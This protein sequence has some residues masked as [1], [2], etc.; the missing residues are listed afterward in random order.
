ML[1]TQPVNH[2]P[3]CDTL[4]ECIDDNDCVKK[5]MVGTCD[6]KT[7]KARCV[8]QES[9]RFLF[10]VLLPD[11]SHTHPENE[12]ISTTRHFFAGAAIDT[13]FAGSL[14]GK[15]MLAYYKPAALPL[16]L[17]D[18]TVTTAYNYDKIASGLVRINSRLTFKDGIVKKTWF[19]NRPSASRT[20]TVY[21][22]PLFSGARDAIAIALA[23]LKTGQANIRIMPLL[24][25]SP[26]SDSLTQEDHLRQ[27]EA[28]RWLLMSTVYPQQ[29]GAYLSAFCKREAASSYWFLSLK[30]M[31][32]EV[33]TFVSQLKADITSMKNA[34]AEE[35]ELGLS[36][37]VE[38]L[39]NNREV[40]APRNQK[41]LMDILRSEAP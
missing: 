38:L 4:P 28:Q 39:L 13:V 9:V 2:I 27:E 6:K 10:T 7:G 12:I 14:R 18:T 19:Y 16:Y 5:G 36:G 33:D 25:A 1:C 8:Y 32:I 24:M 11:S 31:H 40:M 34:W 20:I 3:L 35:Q 30:D 23:T 37:P 41:E 22:D 15:K 29:F 26:Q 21:I 17:F